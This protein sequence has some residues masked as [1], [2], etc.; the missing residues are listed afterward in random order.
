M[1]SSGTL[2]DRSNFT[3]YDT[4]TE[5]WA[6]LGLPTNALQSLSLPDSDDHSRSGLPSSFKI[7]HLAQ[8]TIALSVLTA[9][10][11]HSLRNNSSVPK[12]TV[13]LLHAS[14]EFKSEKLYTLGGK[15]VK[16]EGGLGLIGPVQKTAD[17]YV[18]IHDGFPHHVA[19]T[20]EILGLP[21]TAKREEINA[22][23]LKWKSLDLETAAINSKCVIVALR[24]YEEWDAL[25]QAR[26][27][28]NIPIQLTKLSP[29]APVLPPQVHREADR[30]LRG[31]RVLEL[32]RVIAA[33][34]A[35]RTLAAH[36][37]DVLWITSPNLP[38]LPGIDRDLARGK[39]TAQLDLTTEDGRAKLTELI[40]NADVFIQ[41]YRPGS[42]AAKGFSPSEL[43]KI[44]PSI[45]YASMSAYGNQGPW[46]RN[47]GFDSIIQTGSG[48]N[49]SEAE[50][51]G[52]GEP[53]RPMPCQVLDHASGY[54][55]ATGICAALYKRATEGGS[56]EVDVSLAGTMKY[57][58]SL[59]QFPGNTG[60]DCKVPGEREIER[61]LEARE[62][63]FGELKAVTH[64]A[65]VEGFMPGWDVMPK[66]LGS[67]RAAWMDIEQSV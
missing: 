8:S 27:I 11:F 18:R 39:R 59:G 49:I 7:G 46:G 48:M 42:L 2:L 62:S 10:L 53:A 31:V 16:S 45:V 47:R 55:L 44:N 38:D 54:F 9:S 58:R 60:F 17:G 33:P 3:T 52:Q 36:G 26:F 56:Y 14:L 50:H 30:C 13:P 24:S 25:P 65:A 1:A 23:L 6:H 43:V 19:A 35:G 57:L 12:V 32:S 40:K 64:S 37:A 21:S 22:A 20:L 5:L 66:P 61:Y 63:G 29:G 15:K 41:G 34:V 51:F 67:D 4:I 28:P